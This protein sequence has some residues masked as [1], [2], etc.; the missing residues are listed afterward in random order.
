MFIEFE[1]LKNYIITRS[2]D[3]LH[4]TILY[5]KIILHN[6]VVPVRITVS[7]SDLTLFKLFIQHNIPLTQTSNELDIHFPSLM[8]FQI[9]NR[10]QIIQLSNMLSLSLP[11]EGYSTNASCALNLISTFY[12]NQTN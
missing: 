2:H 11:D 8:L 10:R 9:E 6:R 4:A 7:C 5:L 1:I 3:L 12:E